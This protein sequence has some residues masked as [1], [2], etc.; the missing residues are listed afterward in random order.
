M[1]CLAGAYRATPN[2]TTGLT[3]NML[4]F[5]REVRFPLELLKGGTPLCTSLDL[6]PDKFGEHTIRVRERL[7]KAH[8]IAR[9]HLCANAKRRKDY[10]D[11]K[12]NLIA[13]EEN[14]VVWY[15]DQSR[16]E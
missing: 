2:E 16:K 1:G 4:L 13:Y 6:Q 15:L 8:E 9:K 14:D 7:S 11:V 3:P 12:A 5:G 10:Y